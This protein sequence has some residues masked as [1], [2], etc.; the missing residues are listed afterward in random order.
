[1]LDVKPVKEVTKFHSH[2][3]RPKHMCPELITIIQ[4]VEKQD[5]REI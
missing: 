5:V 2:V 4:Y 1:M 3:F